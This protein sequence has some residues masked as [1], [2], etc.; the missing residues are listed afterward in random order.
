MEALVLVCAMAVAAADCQPETSVRSLYVPDPQP[1]VTGCLRDGMLYAAQS[2]VVVAGTYPKIV[3][4]PQ[5]QVTGAETFQS[6]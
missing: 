3:C 1:N 5:T 4:T 2:G 6:R